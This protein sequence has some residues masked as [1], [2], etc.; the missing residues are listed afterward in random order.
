MRI[1][2]E[3]E[4]GPRS[5]SEVATSQGPS[6]GVRRSPSPDE[7]EGYPSFNASTPPSAA[8]VTT[9]RFSTLVSYF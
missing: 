5:G 4:G 2:S 6:T 8:G 3:M 9:K 1:R 7:G